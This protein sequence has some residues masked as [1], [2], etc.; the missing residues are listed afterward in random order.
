M[1]ASNSTSGALVAMGK[2]NVPDVSEDEDG[3]TSYE[4]RRRN[5]R[6]EGKQKG[7]REIISDIKRRSTK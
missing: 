5:Y 7:V 1:G 4:L 6:K 2:V 3:L